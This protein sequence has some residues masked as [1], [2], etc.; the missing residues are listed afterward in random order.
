MNDTGRGIEPRLID[1]LFEP[2][3]QA[4][5]STARK[6]GG[7][8]LGLAI[9][10]RLVE[11]MGG[12]LTLESAVGQGSR[13][14]F[15]V[16]LASTSQPDVDL[17]VLDSN[18]Q[19]LDELSALEPKLRVLLVE[20]NP[21][22]QLYCQAL[23]EQMGHQVELANDG[24]EAVELALAARH[25]IILMDCHLPA[26]DGFEATR[27]IRHAERRSGERR[28][29]I[30]ALTASAMAED[31]ARCIDAG[32]DEMLSKPFTR[33]EMKALLQRLSVGASSAMP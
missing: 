33:V 10:K 17:R 14:C 12:Q 29:T 8:G 27:Q 11:E 28:R 26:L 7:S 13:F 4:D 20:D 6:H 15:S 18:F 25:D 19:T 1:S 23:L 21:V 32:M 22:N 2:F 24:L 30:V 16:E 9:A 3:V 5:S 31:H